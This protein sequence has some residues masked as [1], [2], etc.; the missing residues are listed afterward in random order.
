MLA[1]SDTSHGWTVARCMRC[2][3]AT[4]ALCA[5]SALLPTVHRAIGKAHT[6]C[7]RDVLGGIGWTHVHVCF[8]QGCRIASWFAWSRLRAATAGRPVWQHCAA[9]SLQLKAWVRQLQALAV[10]GQRTAPQV[11]QDRLVGWC[12][13][14]RCGQSLSHCNG[15]HRYPW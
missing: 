13:G 15:C 2:I 12:Q 11:T 7:L 6:W 4:P 14:W 1:G 8:L 10:K 9:P 3:Q 5:T